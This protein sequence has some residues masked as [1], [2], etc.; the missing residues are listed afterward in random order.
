M[1]RGI[2][3]ASVSRKPDA[4][5]GY[6]NFITSA[7]N[8]TSSQVSHELLHQRCCMASLDVVI[9]IS[10]PRLDLSCV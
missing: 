6:L 5:D 10:N 3:Q 2:Y 9:Y 4:E 8:D 7:A 1:S